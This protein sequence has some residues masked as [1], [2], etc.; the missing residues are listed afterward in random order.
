M[1]G[2]E[3]DHLGFPRLAPRCDVGSVLFG[4]VDDFFLNVNC[5]DRNAR[6]IVITLSETPKRSRSSR[7]V[8]SGCS[9]TNSLKRSA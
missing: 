9:S 4:R 8:A 1:I 3:P 7:N 2:V 5:S 6:Q